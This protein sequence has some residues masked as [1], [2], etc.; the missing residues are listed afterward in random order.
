MIKIIL[1]RVGCGKTREIES[2]RA[3]YDQ[4]N[5]L[6]LSGKKEYTN[7]KK[8]TVK[9]FSEADTPIQTADL[10]GTA[11]I[12][13]VDESQLFDIIPLVKKADNNP[14]FTLILL[15]QSVSILR[16]GIIC[17]TGTCF[18]EYALWAVDRFISGKKNAYE[19]TLNAIKDDN[20]LFVGPQ[21]D[22]KTMR[23]SNKV[24]I[25]KDL[26]KYLDGFAIPV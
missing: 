22:I 7:F 1:G 18:S 19:F 16:D 6:I 4:S 26:E 10:I 20:I 3:F 23:I 8:A 2:K 12:V 17:G 13:I 15:T 5:T 21:Y 11:D 9:I 25:R 24:S 14:D